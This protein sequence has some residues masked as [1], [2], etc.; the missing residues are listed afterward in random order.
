MFSTFMKR[1]A[2]LSG[3][4]ILTLVMQLQAQEIN[5]K[6]VT[7]TYVLKNVT[8]VTSPGNSINGATVVIK[9][10][11]IHAVGTDVS[12]PVDAISV[13][14]DSLTVYAGFID[15]LSQ[16]GIKK[17]EDRNNRNNVEDPGNPPNELAGITPNKSVR[18]NLDPSEKSIEAM[19]KA[20]F[21][22]SHV[23]PGDGILPG[24]GSVVLLAGN[25]TDEMIFRENVSLYGTLNGARRMYPSTVI[26]VMAKYRELYRNAELMKKDR[27]YYASNPSGMQRPSSDRVTE[28]LLPVIDG[29]LP[30]MFQA[31]DIKTVQRVMK[32]QDELGFRLMLAGVKQGWDATE[33]IKSANIPVFLSLDLP[34]WKEDK[35]DS[36][37][38]MSEEKKALEERKNAV[39]MNHYTL[40]SKWSEAGI[41]FG[42]TTMGAKSSSLHQVLNT[43]KQKGVSDDVLLAGLTTGPAALLGLS[44]VAGTVEAGKLANLVVTDGN[45]FDEDGKVRYVF[46]EGKMF[47]YESKPNKGN[48]K[49][50]AKKDPEGLW[51]YSSETPDGTS[52]GEIILK[53]D[54][55]SYSGEIRDKRSGYKFDLDNITVDGSNVSFR[56]NYSDGANQFPLS[57]SLDIDGNTFSGLIDG[58]SIG[59]FP[60]EGKRLPEN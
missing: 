12:I 52:T 38:E 6:P 7:H 18:E 43:M 23:V 33:D 15:G 30:V 2:A 21:T 42:F 47:S 28:A 32:L 19:R 14:A 20:G 55:A 56:F 54:G 5:M 48:G 46:V 57:V 51:S 39:L 4:M 36:A 53:K 25:G 31:E 29:Q 58:G 37:E 9:D 1:W 3:A 60:I 13:D 16:T 44:R 27:T 59:K 40:P 8:V 26:G 45:Y 11:L 17:P 50:D 22:M 35:T 34:E 10:G 24:K 49:G 41:R